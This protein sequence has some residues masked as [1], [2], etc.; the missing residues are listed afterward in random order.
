LTEHTE[1]IIATT[2]FTFIKTENIRQRAIV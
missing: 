2:I 1:T